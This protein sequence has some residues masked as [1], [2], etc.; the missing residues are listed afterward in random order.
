MKLLLLLLLGCDGYWISLPKDDFKPPPP[1]PEVPKADVTEV[2]VAGPPEATVFG[3]A[4]VSWDKGCEQYADWWEV[5]SEDGKLVQRKV[6][7]H[8]HVDEQAFLRQGDPIPVDPNQTLWIR[9]HMNNGVGYA[10]QAMKGTVAKGFEPAEWPK[11][12][13]EGLEKVDPQPPPC[14]F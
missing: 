1:A 3:V 11:G 5:V 7:A 4:I 2:W 14:M 9:A 12:L 10:G 13:G 6:M 8:S